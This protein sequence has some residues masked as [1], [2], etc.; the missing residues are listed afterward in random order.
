[1]LDPASSLP[2]LE[3]LHREEEP[4]PLVLYRPLR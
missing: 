3:V 2:G 1:L 4:L